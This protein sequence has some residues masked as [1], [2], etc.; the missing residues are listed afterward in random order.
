MKKLIYLLSTTFLAT[1]LF[2]SVTVNG[3]NPFYVTVLQPDNTAIEWVM[4][5]TYTISWED[6]LSQPVDVFLF[7]PTVPEWVRLSPYP[8]GV[9]GTT[10]Q[11]TIPN[12]TYVEGSQY[13][14]RVQSKI[15]PST[16]TDDGA[17]FSI[18]YA[19][20]NPTLLTPSVNGI[21]YSKRTTQIISWIDDLNENVEIWLENASL[22]YSQMLTP[23]GGVSGSTWPWPI[24]DGLTPDDDYKIKIISVDY[25]SVNDASDQPFAITETTG[26]IYE[27][28][29]P[30]NALLE[31]G[32]TSTHLISWR[33]DLV[34]PVD[35][36]VKDITTPTAEK[37][38]GNDIV[39]STMVWDLGNNTGGLAFIPGNYYKIVI[40]SSE[41]PTLTYRESLH[42]RITATIGDVQHIYQ[43]TTNTSWTV[44]TTH[45]ISWLDNLDEPVNVYYNNGGSDILI[46]AGVVGTTC[47]WPV[48]PT[49]MTTG[50]NICTIIVKSSL[51][52]LVKRSSDPFDLTLSSGSEVTVIQPS[53]SGL[54]WALNTE[55]YISWDND[56]P[57][58]VTI[59]LI[60]YTTGSE[61]DV[62]P[63]VGS[64]GLT[65]STYVWNIG[66]GTTYPVHATYKVRVSSIDDPTIFDESD[67]YFAITPSAGTF[68]TV[69]QPNGGEY[70]MFNTAHIISWNDNCAENVYIWLE[71]Y[72][73][74][75]TWVETIGIQ[76]ATTGTTVGVGGS[77]YS[78]MID[79]SDITTTGTKFKIRVASVTGQAGLTDESE[80]FYIVP[81]GK[82]A[83]AGGEDNGLESSVNVYPNPTN[84]LF[85]VVAPVT[86]NKVEV[87]NL[88]GQLIY[89]NIPESAQTKVDISSYQAGIYLV[90]IIIEN[91]V[92]TKKLFVQ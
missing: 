11:W 77:T 76:T 9:T 40:R 3:Q 60:E 88:L 52:E 33:D 24:S 37:Q 43:P 67:H 74:G 91:E 84:G 55:H 89:S 20:A 51:N 8:A 63:I 29:Q 62:I 80:F 73:S 66:D 27:I 54:S 69:L 16:Y 35:I 41:D 42:F 30:N 59:D 85:N 39:G 64:P 90:N 38:I 1:L 19:S 44:G 22:T 36:Y 28:H 31:W 18:V 81:W 7:N 57:E 83:S 4:G 17:L 70:W 47:Y 25:P 71:E 82:S 87:R 50:Q 14:I 2:M 72:T 65:G 32:I 53:I 23:A 48:P 68:V 26:D 86:I 10:L 56:F 61:T 58:E 15:S 45:L 49:G 21:V 6:N 78:W 12:S 92:I 5:E 79:Q 34:E 46:Q 13:F 75:G